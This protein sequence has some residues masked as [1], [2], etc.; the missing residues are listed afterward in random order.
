MTWA[1]HEVND[2]FRLGEF[3][4]EDA[5]EVLGNPVAWFWENGRGEWL[6]RVSLA[7]RKQ[8]GPMTINN[9]MWNGQFN[10]RGIRLEKG[11]SNIG[12]KGSRHRR[13]MALD[14]HFRDTELREVYRHFAQ[15]PEHWLRV[16][17]HRYERTQGGKPITW[18]HV[19]A[20]VE[21]YGFNA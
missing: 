19:D 11:V 5:G 13:A 3:L 8:F 2:F 16:G 15:H 1:D 7:L 6:D 17:V 10:A 20:G 14:C 9:W 4:P 18:L 21:V 12:G